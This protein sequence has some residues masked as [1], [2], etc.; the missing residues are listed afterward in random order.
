VKKKI[1]RRKTSFEG[2]RHI[3][4]DCSPTRKDKTPNPPH[5]KRVRTLTR[6][7]RGERRHHGFPSESNPEKRGT[8]LGL[9]ARRKLDIS[10]NWVKRSSKGNIP[11][12]DHIS[13]LNLGVEKSSIIMKGVRHN[14]L[15]AAALIKM[16]FLQRNNKRRR[17]RIGE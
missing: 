9:L 13:G 11:T 12:P 14:S 2:N 17:S 3:P 16:G 6:Q 4:N 8:K 7:R 10:K 15:R 1:L 5:R